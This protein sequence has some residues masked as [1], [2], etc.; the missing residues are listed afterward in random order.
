MNNIYVDMQ[1]SVKKSAVILPRIFQ[2]PISPQ[3][4][5]HIR[6]TNIEENDHFCFV[7]TKLTF[8]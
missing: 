7:F 4:S 2:N 5:F 8:I 1:G 3:N 6:T